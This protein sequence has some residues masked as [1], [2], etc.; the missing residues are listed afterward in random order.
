VPGCGAVSSATDAITGAA[1]TP[2]G[3]PGFVTGFLGGAV[4]DEPRAALVGREVLSSG[5]NAADAAVA[6]GFALAVTLPSRAGLGAGGACLAYT[7]GREAVNGGFPEAILFTPVAP[8]PAGGTPGTAPFSIG[9]ADRPAAVPMLARGLFLLHNRYGSR[10]FDAL[11]SPAEQLARSGV[12][13]S[14]AL[15]RD[16]SLV[17]APLFADSGARSVF[18]PGGAVLAEGQTLLQ[19]DLAVTLSQ[20][21]TAGVGDLYQGALAR[22]FAQASV[23]I[24][25]PVPLDDLRAA[26]PKVAPALIMADKND[27]VAF[28]PPPADGGLAA[29]AAFDRLQHGA[30]PAAA[31]ARALSVAARWRA[32]GISPK[33]LSAAV[34]LPPGTLPPL[35]ASTG[36]AALDQKGNVALCVVTM[37]NL[38]GT[39]RILP[40]L[41]F[42][43]AASPDSVPLPLLAAGVAWSERNQAFHAATTGTGQ[44]GA[45]LAAALALF[46]VLHTGK[47][48]ATPVPD[49]G[50]ANGI[51]CG[52]YLPGDQR[53][54]TGWTDPRESGLAAAGG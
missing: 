31:S 17:A 18:G 22:R 32:G 14:R 15:V 10:P 40:G 45:P 19:P 2:I 53:G 41:G 16:L 27:K 24:G 5:G 39:G 1:A 34:D 36:F 49:P 44:E 26:L 4:A 6:M 23:A 8:N 21:R 46:E 28:L 12:R 11:I 35:P 51:V 52:G 50:R 13:A 3:Q 30:D 29:A 20:L 25:G 47:P 37:D 42:L 7:P 48:P 9:A 43:A 54:C 38:F 33:A